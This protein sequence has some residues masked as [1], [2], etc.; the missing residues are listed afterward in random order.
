MCSRIPPLRSLSFRYFLISQYTNFNSLVSLNLQIQQLFSPAC[1]YSAIAF[2]RQFHN[3]LSPSHFQWSHF[4]LDLYHLGQNYSNTFW[5]TNA[6]FFTLRQSSLD[7]AVSVTSL[8][9]YF[10]NFIILVNN[11][12]NI[13]VT[14]DRKPKLLHLIIKISSDLLFQPYFSHLSSLTSPGSPPT[15]ANPL[16]S[17]R[18]VPTDTLHAA[19]PDFTCLKFSSCWCVTFNGLIRYCFYCYPKFFNMSHVYVLSYWKLIKVTS[20]VGISV[21]LT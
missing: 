21:H 13:S 20:T 3:V 10:E 11:L 19:G 6:S 4:H 16:H 7:V 14:Y 5:C 8:N 18:P 12:Q 17:L 9:Y 15:S 1:F 2:L